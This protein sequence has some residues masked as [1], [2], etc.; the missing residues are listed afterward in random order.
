MCGEKKHPYRNGPGGM[1]KYRSRLEGIIV[2]GSTDWEFR[3]FPP[4]RLTTLHNTHNSGYYRWTTYSHVVVNQIYFTGIGMHFSYV[5]DFLY[6]AHEKK[7]NIYEIYK[8]ISQSATERYRMR[9]L[10]SL[11]N[12]SPTPAAVH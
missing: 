3:H 11:Y 7:K 5:R 12:P 10:L 8:I 4:S 1:C 6:N 9:R 2:Q